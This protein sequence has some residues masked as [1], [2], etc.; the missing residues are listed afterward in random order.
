MTPPGG[1]SPVLSETE[2]TYIAVMIVVVALIGSMGI[3]W[4][5]IATHLAHIGVLAQGDE[6]ALALPG[7]PQNIGLSPRLILAVALIF[8]GSCLTAIWGLSLWTRTKEAQR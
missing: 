1:S 3:W 5:Q 6:V 7:A 8:L 4:P 2:W